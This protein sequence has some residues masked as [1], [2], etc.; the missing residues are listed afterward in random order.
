VVTLHS[1]QSI[2]N[3]NSDNGI[4]FNRCPKN[5]ENE[6]TAQ[7]RNQ[8]MSDFENHL[9][10]VRERNRPPPYLPLPM[11]RPSWPA[12]RV[13]SARKL[14]TEV[15]TSHS[16][17][18]ATLH[19][20]RTPKIIQLFPTLLPLK[21][22][23]MQSTHR[24][25]TH[26]C[27]HLCQVADAQSQNDHCIHYKDSKGRK[28]PSEGVESGKTGDQRLMLKAAIHRLIHRPVHN[29]LLMGENHPYKKS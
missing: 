9:D 16:D 8:Y 5:D 11:D 29:C 10:H 13:G 26:L 23:D 24:H 3:H 7:C 4:K 17:Y 15:F 21:L 2:T 25:S 18:T 22:A 14:Q 20:H 19:T 28:S 1:F 27:S 12:L 6:L